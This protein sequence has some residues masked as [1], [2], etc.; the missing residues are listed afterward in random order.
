MT[1]HLHVVLL[2]ITL[3][4]TS[5]AET[6][7]TE[8]TVRLDEGQSPETADLK[9]FSWL[10]GEWKGPGLGAVC[11]E[12]WSVPAGGCMV[13]TFRMVKS[14]ELVFSEFFSISQ[15]ANGTLLRVKHFH[16]DFVG[17]EEKD[18]S[19]DFPLIKVDGT[20]AWFGGLTYE[21]QKDGSLKAYVAMRKK[22]GSFSETVFHFQKQK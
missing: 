18:K 8:H 15:T 9:Q 20:T 3:V 22:D 21:L 10:R 13:G 1:R 7:L 5:F 12:T 6:K 19:V 2:F 4:S 14:E 11:H 17:W 16:P